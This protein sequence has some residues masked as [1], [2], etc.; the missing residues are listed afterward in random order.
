MIFKEEFFIPQLPVIIKNGWNSVSGKKGSLDVW[1]MS[2][3]FCEWKLI[4]MGLQVNSRE[5]NF[6]S[7]TLSENLYLQV[8]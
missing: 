8:P 7:F 5:I 2:E 1:D 4:F 3:I 6:Y